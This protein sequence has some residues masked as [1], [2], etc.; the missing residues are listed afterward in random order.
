[1]DSESEEDKYKDL[2]VYF[3]KQ[4]W[5]ELQ[6]WEKVR[7]KN[8]KRNYEA[9]IAIGLNSPKP[10][11]MCRRSRSRQPP[12]EDS[13]DPDE[14]WTPRQERAA[15]APKTFR[16]PYKRDFVHRQTTKNV[17]TTKVQVN[18]E[19]AP[20]PSSSVA[21]PSA[22]TPSASTSSSD[23]NRGDSFEGFT[24]DELAAFLV[25]DS[26]SESEE[27]G[28]AETRS[29][30]LKADCEDCQTFF[31]DVCGLHGPALFIP[32]TA[33]EV[34]LAHRARLTTPQG[35]SIR[36]SKIPN[37]G[38]GAWNERGVIPRG[39]HFGPYQGG[40]THEEEAILSGYSWVITKG[41]NDHEYIDAKSE[42][43]SNWMRYVNCARNE[44]EQNLVAFQYK[45]EIYYRSCKPIP[46]RC[47]L[48]VWYGDEYGRELGIRWDLMWENKCR[49]TEADLEQD[50]DIYPCPHCTIAFTAEQYLEKHT[51]RTHPEEYVVILR[52]R[53]LRN[54]S[55]QSGAQ[56]PVPPVS[57]V[58][59]RSGRVHKSDSQASHRCSECGKSFTRSGD[60][61]KHQRTHTGEKP[62]RCSECG[63]SFTR[64]DSLE[65]HQRT[66]TGE[67]PYRC[68]ECGKSF[69][70]S[71]SL[72]IHQRTHT[73]EKP[74][75]CSDCGK[76]F[77]QS[78]SLVSH[79]RTHTGEKPYRCSDCGKRF[80]QS[81]N[82][83][84]HQ[85]THTGEK[86]YR[87]SDCGKRFSQSS[88]LE[89]HQRTH[90]GEKPYR[91]SDCGKRFSQSRSLVSHQRTHS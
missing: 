6:E 35:M 81:G 38:L 2:K 22:E 14:D 45:G 61:K 11:F 28:K 46:P 74:Y 86:P 42:A 47:E 69:S 51:K 60:L 58:T 72:K 33:A 75:R 27:S 9:M 70:H 8:M 90:T 62:Y 40:V 7:Y 12:V 82:L 24:D 3:S 4:E 56:L 21:G 20:A 87:C 30:E 36:V 19:K 23:E 10:T 25:Y 48:L 32:D 83:E 64:S 85:R 78:C 34:G 31:I 53:S 63:K 43:N 57:S 17:T 68:S 67:K 54:Q 41:K 39:A 91:C 1:M 44:E 37:A 88:S 79:Q 52:A 29:A 71:V 49:S 80:S 77:S 65:T 26:P 13:S 15:A 16:P 66:H 55:S 73:G 5:A 84:A 18:S 89:T 50:L 59:A 76:S